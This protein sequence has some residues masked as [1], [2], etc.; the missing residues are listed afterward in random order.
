MHN[1]NPAVSPDHYKSKDGRIQLSQAIERI[2][3]GHEGDEVA[4]LSPILKYL[5]R[6][7]KKVGQCPL[8]DIDKAIWYFLR[9]R[10]IVEW[11]KNGGMYPDP[12][13]EAVITDKGY[14]RI[15]EE[16]FDEAVRDEAY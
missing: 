11:R 3:E 10:A 1:A 12:A 6:Y 14:L 13:N 8:Q 9:L 7:G 5:G 4:N 15:L 16:K 2:C